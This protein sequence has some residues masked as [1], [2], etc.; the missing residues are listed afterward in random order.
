MFTAERTGNAKDRWRR[1]MG[2]LAASAPGYADGRIYVTILKRGGSKN[3]R[4][5]AL[6]ARDGKVKWAKSL[7]SR[8]ESSPLGIGGRVYFGSEDGTVYALR[9]SDGRL[10]WRFKAAGAVK[11]APA[12]WDGKLYF[13]DY[14]GRMYAIRQRDGRRVWTKATRGAHFGTSSGQFYAS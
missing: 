7:P 2:R 6:R 3:G 4:V 12:L 14:S 9:A 13:G 5:A 8:S 11:G 10:V 1:R